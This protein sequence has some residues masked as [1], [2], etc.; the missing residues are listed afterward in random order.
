[1]TGDI[2]NIENPRT[3]FKDFST[4]QTIEELS[5]VTLARQVFRDSGLEPGKHSV[6]V[7]LPS[8]ENTFSFHTTKGPTE[9]SDPDIA[10]ILVMIEILDTMEGILW[11]LIRGQGLAYSC[12]LESNIES[13]LIN[14]TIYQSPNAHKAFEKARDVF[15]ELV[16]QKM[17][18]SP[19]T[20][21]GAKSAV[22]YSLVARE[23]TMDRAALQSF[24][25]QALKKMPASYNRDL[26]LAI[27][28]SSLKWFLFFLYN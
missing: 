1:V 28:V 6:L 13:G 12:Y 2:L 3:A 14:F 9:F 27:Q 25:N 15:E 23:N 5:P 17:T 19:S 20:I 21:E 24:V 16:E 11:K 18:L 26:L 8:I 7:T 4:S 10:P 22:I